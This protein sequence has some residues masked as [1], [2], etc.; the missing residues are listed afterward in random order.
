MPE[1]KLKEYYGLDKP[2]YMQYFIWMGNLLSGN[3]GISAA[4]GAT[5]ES[6]ISVGEDAEEVER[7][8]RRF[9]DRD[10]RLIT[11]SADEQGSADTAEVTHE[12]LFDHWDELK[13]WLDGSRE[14]IRFSRHL[15]S[16]ARK[17]EQQGRPEHRED[18]H[19]DERHGHEHR[20]GEEGA[21]Q[22]VDARAVLVGHRR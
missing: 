12:A 1:E 5:I 17:W 4:G 16:D 9:A 10:A 2:W 14:D 19:G 8:I 7:V 13:D 21:Q 6:L 11:L 3:L 18:D 22:F 20:I 15:D